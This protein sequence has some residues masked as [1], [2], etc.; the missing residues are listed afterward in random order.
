M[1]E[2]ID[3]RGF[4]AKAE[5]GLAAAESE[6]ANLRYNTCSR[7]AY[8]SCFHAAVAALLA[9][10]VPL[11]QGG[12]VWSHAFVQAE[13]VRRCINERKRYPSAL[14]EVLSRTYDLRQAA[15]YTAEQI[16]QTAAQRA[17]RRASEFVLAIMR[18]RQ[19]GDQP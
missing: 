5:E 1:A 13:F 6:Y 4:L 12:G 18:E 19:G 8:Y 17:L 2:A 11:P 10:G 16:S 15:D 7:L 9:A 3:Q 14:G